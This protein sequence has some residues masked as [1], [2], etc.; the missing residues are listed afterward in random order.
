MLCLGLE[1]LA[2]LV[3]IDLLFS[4]RSAFRFP[5]VTSSMPSADV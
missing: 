3:E 5:N 2:R 1:L 4:N